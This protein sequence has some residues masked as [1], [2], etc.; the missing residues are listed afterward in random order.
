VDGALGEDGAAVVLGRGERGDSG[1]VV[2]VRAR[3]ELTVD[4]A[5]YVYG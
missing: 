4:R 2:A 1:A 3:R 5:E